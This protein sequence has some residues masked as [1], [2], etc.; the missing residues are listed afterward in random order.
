M[1]DTLRHTAEMLYADPRRAATNRSGPAHPDRYRS[2]VHCAD[3]FA[4]HRHCPDCGRDRY[5]EQHHGPAGRCPDT[6]DRCC[7]EWYCLTC[8]AALLIGDSPVA[9]DL[10]RPAEIRDR[11]A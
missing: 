4:P 2:E 7:P 10:L 6:A 11:V 5:F 1:P 9:T 8:G 3:R